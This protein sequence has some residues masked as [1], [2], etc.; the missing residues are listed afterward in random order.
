MRSRQ[1]KNIKPMGRGTVDPNAN[2]ARI[3]GRSGTAPSKKMAR[4]AP[5]S[6]GSGR[7]GTSSGSSARKIPTSARAGTVNRGSR[8]ARI[9]PVKPRT[10]NYKSGG[11][12]RGAGCATKGVS[13]AKVY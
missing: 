12:V 5:P 8:D 1:M 7:S 3:G 13:K 4:T 11:K 10:K 6:L 9:G 2:M